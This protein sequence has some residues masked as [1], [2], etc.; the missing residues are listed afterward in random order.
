MD[1]R[2]EVLV[3]NGGLLFM[4]DELT[5]RAPEGGSIQLGNLLI[6]LHSSFIAERYEFEVL[7]NG[8]WEIVGYSEEDFGDPSFNGFLVTLP[9]P[10]TLQGDASLK[11]R[12][13]YLFLNR[14]S[15][16][17]KGYS[18]RVPVYPVMEYN[19]TSTHFILTLPE[20]AEL[21]EVDSP[22]S[23]TNSSSAGIWSV[24][25]EAEEVASPA[26]MNVTV[27]YK[28]APGDEYL[29]NCQG[30]ERGINIKQGKL[31]M[32]DTYDLIN[33]G[34][35]LRKIK[36]RL[37]AGAT[38][39]R[40]SD[41][42]GPLS[43]I[44]SDA[45]DYVE[46]TIDSRYA[47]APFY[48]WIFMVTYDMPKSAYVEDVGGT[49]TLSYPVL[50][51]PH[52]VRD[53]RVRVTLPE[54]GS[55][56]SST[57]EPTSIKDSSGLTSLIF[58]LG[59]TLPS[60][61]RE[62]VVEYRGDALTPLIRPLG[63]VLLAAAFIGVVYLVRRRRAEPEKEVI[64][65]AER[66]DL[67]DFLS[68]YEERV[69]LL[70]EQR[71]IERDFMARKVSQQQFD[72]MMADLNRR[73]QGLLRRLKGT[74]DELAQAGPEIAEKLQQLRRTEDDLRRL[75]EDLRSLETRYRARRISRKDYQNRRRDLVRR[76][77]EALNRI[78][79]TLAFLK[80]RG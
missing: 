76:R 14:V 78:E 43:S 2:R 13:N 31:Q 32:E 34:K 70:G 54:G 67:G 18:A 47:V 23:F 75:E 49:P 12:A 55:L 45:G 7:V 56:V 21:V 65:E 15:Y 9:Y 79:A 38:N 28:P 74:E 24:E 26:D 1:A 11:V 40:A 10:V 57:P 59:A 22:V 25:H 63:G 44:Y 5:L 46:A 4:E 20:G 6:G 66:A 69:S 19:L 35:T 16:T 60:E 30:L 39:V 53:M 77:G 64:V 80:G 62:V 72:G 27:V 3:E 58:D 50:G 36:V 71:R 41:G 48:R 73:T 29:L 17:T 37:P 42:V 52:Y 51:F 61:E 68:L 33:T 8:E